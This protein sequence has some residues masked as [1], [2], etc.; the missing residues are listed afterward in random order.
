M[1]NQ[2]QWSLISGILLFSFS[3]ALPTSTEISLAISILV[4]TCKNRVTI[5]F[6]AWA[7][8]IRLSS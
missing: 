4:S 3:K 6:L 5:K 7:R 8:W 1:Y 2:L